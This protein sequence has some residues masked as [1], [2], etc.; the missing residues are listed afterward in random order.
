MID[1][2]YWTLTIEILF[3][4]LIGLFVF[5][6]GMKRLLTFYLGWLL[7]TLTAFY[8]GF[9]HLLFMKILLVRQAPYFIFGGLIA[10]FYSNR[11]V[12]TTKE[13][14]IT[15][16]GIIISAATPFYISSVLSSD[17]NNRTNFFGIYDTTAQVLILLLFLFF[18][19]VIY[20]SKYIHNEKLF[21][22]AKKLGIITYPLYLLHQKLGSLVLGST[23]GT[24][25]LYSLLTVLGMIIFSYNI[26][27]QEEVWRKKIY[28]K[29]MIKIGLTTPKNV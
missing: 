6:F 14:I 25:T 23:F 16:S 1:G 7:L 10:Y 13:K 21:S 15:I 24:I 18:P 17:S 28:K 2:S 19:C 3:Y 5:I 22:V 12:S 27:M 11:L 4:F 9:Y 20:V 8:F 29:L 26:G